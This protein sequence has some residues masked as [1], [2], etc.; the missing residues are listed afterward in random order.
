MAAKKKGTGKAQSKAKAKDEKK[1]KPKASSPA[2]NTKSSSPA[3][4]SK[5]TR[6]ASKPK[7]T[8]PKA[9]AKPKT[10][11][12]PTTKKNDEDIDLRA[13]SKQ[14]TALDKSLEKISLNVKDMKDENRTNNKR[15]KSLE[16][17][18]ET[19]IKREELIMDTFGLNS[20][21]KKGG[22]S[23]IRELNSSLIK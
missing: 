15:L 20:H 13:I 17:K 22:K 1:P 14:L 19:R 2:K 11:P 9:K 16:T 18:L 4:K 3:S 6:T 7:T 10:P 21:S 23:E 12:A 5:A 8:V